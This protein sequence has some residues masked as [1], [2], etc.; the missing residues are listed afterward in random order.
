MS[1]SDIA[2]ETLQSIAQGEAERR[3]ETEIISASLPAPAD[4]A[5]DD[6]AR[7]VVGA[8][9][10]ISQAVPYI[11][12]LHKRFR[13]KPRGKA[14]ILGCQTWKQFCETRLNRCDRTIR[15]A[16]TSALEKAATEPESEADT[17]Q[18][19]GKLAKCLAANENAIAALKCTISNPALHDLK[20]C[21]DPSV[22]EAH[23]LLLIQAC[24][25]EVARLERA[26]TD[27]ALLFRIYERNGKGGN[28]ADPKAEAL[29]NLLCGVLGNNQAEVTPARQ[30]RFKVTL[31]L[32]E[33][34]IVDLAGFFAGRQ[35]SAQEPAIAHPL[36]VL[37]CL[38]AEAATLAGGVNE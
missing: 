2:I 17:D 31:F 32:H 14:N 19:E 18:L 37:T 13:R 35:Y 10:K 9:A 20:V 4:M 33:D 22:T 5:D 27:H 12:E 7:F 34:N 36:D 8:F 29:T 16:I 23:H 28:L 25:E 3:Y 1:A 11:A 21:S 24:E 6:L 30:Q 26:C 15:Y 38:T